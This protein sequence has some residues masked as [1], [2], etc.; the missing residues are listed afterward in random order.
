MDEKELADVRQKALEIAQRNKDM[1][2]RLTSEAIKKLESNSTKK[3]NSDKN[4]AKSSVRSSHSKLSGSVAT[5][6]GNLEKQLEEEREE[7]KKLES[8]LTEIKKMVETLSKSIHGQ[9]QN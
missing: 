5:Y 9:F 7:R 6:V 4:S 8:E 2:P 3:T 1:D